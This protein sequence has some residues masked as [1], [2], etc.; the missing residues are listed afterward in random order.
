MSIQT[1]N[2]PDNPQIEVIKSGKTGLFTNYIYKAIP[3][4]FDESMSYYETLLGLLHYL[5][6]VIIPTVN[7]NADAVAELQTLYEELRTYVDDYFKGLDVQEEI[8]NKLDEMV[9]DGTLPEIIASYLNSKALFGFDN[10]ESMKNATNLING[11]Y[12]YTLGF[13]TKNDNG[14]ATYKIRNI[15]SEDVVDEKFIIALNNSETLIAELVITEPLNPEKLGAYGDGLHDDTEAIQSA[16][17]S[18]KK[19]LLIDFYKCTETIN[20][21]NAFQLTINGVDFSKTALKFTDGAYL[22][23]GSNSNVNEIRMNNFSIVGDRTQNVILKINYVT[24]IMLNQINIAES[25]GYLM[26][27]NHGDIVFIDKCTF[28]GSNQLNV[29]QPCKG[30]K[31]TSAN[32]VY[33]SNCNIWNL[34]QFID[35]IG[36]TRTVHLSNNWIEFVNVIINSQ[37]S[38]FNHT[39]LIVNDNNIVFSPHGDNTD[40][41]N[42]RI[43]NLDNVTEPFDILLNVKNNNIIYYTTHITQAL[44]ELKNIASQCNVYIENNI[45]FTRLS[46]MSAY[47]L[48]VDAKRETKLYYTSTTNADA[49]YGCQTDGVLNQSLSPSELNFKNVNLTTTD[50]E[51]GVVASLKNGHIWYNNGLYIKDNDTLKRIPITTRETITNIPDTSTATTEEVGAKLN[52]LMNILRRTTI[53]K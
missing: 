45:L 1:N 10:V 53:I 12:A 37:N 30:I 18:G 28:A 46:Q 41:T 38:N 6:N 7:N 51:L 50:N 33:I 21:Q 16:F 43:I 23:I 48:K 24:N 36:L 35:I 15:T 13:H 39:N 19:I 17:D 11:S 22:N 42:S 25:N 32:P 26:E 20:I 8:N 49:D 34:T 40:F 5:K 52:A 3:L 27:L 2:L 29:W 14:N 4:A 9:E 31:M 47:A 44:V